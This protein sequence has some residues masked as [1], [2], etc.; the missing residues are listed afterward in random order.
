MVI[1]A[2][3][4]WGGVLGTKWMKARDGREGPALHPR[5]LPAKARPAQKIIRL[6]SENPGFDA[7]LQNTKPAMKLEREMQAKRM[8]GVVR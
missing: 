3:V 1:A 7:P 2:G 6:R 8:G 5:P 4:Q